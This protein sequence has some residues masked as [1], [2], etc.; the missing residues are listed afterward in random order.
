MQRDKS[1]DLA[2][3]IAIIL[4]MYG[5]LRYTVLNMDTLYGWIYSF[6][7]PFFIYIT[8]LLTGLKTEKKSD[9]LWS[10]IKKILFPYLIWNV[11]GY[12]ISIV[13]RIQQMTVSQ[14]IHG[15]VFGDNLKC[16]LPTWYLLSYFWVAL[17]AI[18]VLPLLDTI[19]KLIAAD[20]ISIGLVFG[21]SFFPDMRVYFRLKG[22]IVLLPFFIMGYLV[23]KIDFKLPWWLIPILLYAGFKM[24]R[25]NAVRSWRSVTVGNGDI[26]VP[27]LYLG[28][29]VCTI[30]AM[31]AICSYLAKIPGSGIIGILGRHTLFILCTHWVIGNVL[32]MYM[33]YGNSLFLG[34][35]FIECVFVGV[36]EMVA[37][38][39]MKGKINAGQKT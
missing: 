29:A 30:L 13:L 9:Q 21:I 23:K 35:L 6:H 15:L 19:W 11:V 10:K 34:V 26:C 27:Y 25:L 39:Q 33:D 16:N 8:G 5:H 4:V 20:V 1:L 17:F 36:F 18:Y 22:A 24:E 14:F 32:V 31:T 2:K 28:S 37:Y 7:M 38:L 3:G 12:V